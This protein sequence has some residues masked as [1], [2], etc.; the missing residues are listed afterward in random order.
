MLPHRLA[1]NAHTI[2]KYRAKKDNS[3]AEFFAGG[4]LVRNSGPKAALGGGLTF[5][6][7]SAVVDMLSLSR[8]TPE[9]VFPSLALHPI[10]R[11]YRED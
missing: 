3:V 6:A 9:Y 10:D 4:I 7:F 11:H 8:E 2:H 1:D 5:A